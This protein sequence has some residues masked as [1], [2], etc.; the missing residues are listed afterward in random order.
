MINPNSH[1]KARSPG[2]T[3]IE[4][5]VSLG[6]FVFAIVALVGVIPVSMK[7][8]Q[9]TSTENY[10][11]SVMEGIRDDLSLAL[12]AKMAKSPQYKLAL[13]DTGTTTPVDLKFKE[14]GEIAAANEAAVFRII[15]SC[16]RPA[17]TAVDSGP[18]Q[19]SL[20]ATWPAKALPGREVGAIDLVAAFQP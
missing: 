9:T 10:S 19:L 14:N 11:M 2:F 5:I 6:I 8:V 17:G 4:V 15:G 1:W 16:R 13:P 3:L 12:A 18:V 7:E 20:R